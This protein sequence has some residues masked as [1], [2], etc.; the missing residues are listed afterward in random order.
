MNKDALCKAFCDGLQWEKVQV[1]HVLT[2]PFRL[3]DGD[4]VQ[5]Y[6][7][8]SAPRSKRFR[9]E[10]DGTSLSVLEA[11][12]LDLA[13]GQR[14][15]ALD[16]IL[17][18][19]GIYRDRESLALRTADLSESELPSAALK[20]VAVLLRIQD[21]QLMSPKIVRSTFREDAIK[22]IHSRFDATAHVEENGHIF[23]EHKA[24]PVDLVIRKDD[25]PPLG[26]YF[27]TSNESGLK[28]LVTKFEL[29]RQSTKSKILL[30]V[31]KAKDNPLQEPT[32][33]MAQARLDKVL[34]FR[35]V[36]A[37]ALRNIEQI[38]DTRP[39]YLQ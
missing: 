4:P 34:S 30:L 36:E 16:S 7:I 33:A 26:I 12:G 3:M 5:F 2:T 21:L 20:F 13:R 8:E 27:G 11:G 38:L 15:H 14:A 32:Y 22:A 24:I 17:E 6:V 37:D 1:G 19:Y 18:E 39:A 25:L 35:D 23:A 31:E 9:L 10:D 28:A 29:E